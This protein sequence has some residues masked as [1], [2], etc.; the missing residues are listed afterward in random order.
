MNDATLNKS[1]CIAPATASLGECPAE[2]SAD[3]CWYV[4]IIR[5]TDNQLYTGIT[6]DIQRRWR[7]HSTGK[8]G[9]RYFRGRKPA[10]LC[11]LET[12]PDRSHASKREAA[13]KQL[14]R[15]AKE[16]LLLQRT[17]EQNARL[18]DFNTM[19]HHNDHA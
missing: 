16:Q 14:S 15:R 6:T 10:A 3:K 17:A 9:A 12:H 1:S 7:E 18:N 2:S 5:S 11:L 8:A 4:Y 13:L 19:F